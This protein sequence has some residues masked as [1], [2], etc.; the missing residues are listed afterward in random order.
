MAEAA[1]VAAARR[2]MDILGKIVAFLAVLG[3]LVVIHELGHFVVARWCGVKVVRFSVGFG[4]VVWSRRFGRDRTEWAL[5]AVPLGGYVKMADEREGDV[6][7]SDLPRAFNRQGVGKRIAIVAAGPIANLLLAVLL[8]AGTF[9]AGIPGQKALLAEPAPGTPAATAG[10]RDGDLVTAVDGAPV[11]SWQDLRWRL[12]RVSGAADAALEV[13]RPDGS[14][15]TRV[16]SL[17]MLTASDWEAN[18]MPLLGLKADFGTPLVDDVAADK[19]A[20]QAGLKRGDRIVAVDGVPARSPADVA[21]RTNARPA[22]PVVFRIARDGG[23][24]DAT[25][26]TEAVEQ[27]GRRIGLA[28]IRLKVDPEV[29]ARLGVTVRYGI[30]DALGQGARKTWELSVFTLKMLG[31]ILIGEASV[32]NISGPITL[33]DYAGQSAQAGVLVFVGYLALISISLG[34]LNLLPVPLLDGGHL[35]YYFAEIAK[36]SPVSDRTFEVGQRIGMA[37]LAMLMAL[38]LFNDLS[39]L[40]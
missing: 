1:G 2:L 31:R 21:M 18:F 15:S 30:V 3:I 19:P 23:E 17:A 8:F 26:I 22:A 28:G 39:R 6:A 36:G 29:A 27:N 7:P 35:L 20:A 5:S 32:K 16:L 14:R 40:F 34:V 24:F 12:L 4:R 38:A 13:E 33:A 11:Q 25:V 10:V 9:V 37:V